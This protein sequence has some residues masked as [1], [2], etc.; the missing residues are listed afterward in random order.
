VQA[1]ILTIL[2]LI[3]DNDLGNNDIHV[4]T[5]RSVQS[6]HYQ[7]QYNQRQSH[8]HQRHNQLYNGLHNS[9]SNHQRRSSNYYNN[10]NNNRQNFDTNND[11]QKKYQ[12]MQQVSLDN[13]Q[14]YEV[15]QQHHKPAPYITGNSAKEY[16]IEVLVAVDKKMREYHGENL[17]SYVLTLMS[18]VS[19]KSYHN[20]YIYF[21]L[22]GGVTHE[23][24]CCLSKQLSIFNLKKKDFYYFFHFISLK[25]LLFFIREKS[26]ET[27]SFMDI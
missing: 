27:F 20:V 7:N 4:R 1:I 14:W 12:Q 11:H 19:N 15:Y 9:Y 25:V 16:T 17:Q 26:H 3:A 2:L 21:S 6:Y 22:Y 18:I 8:R 23:I 5:K 24:L 13:D 10:N